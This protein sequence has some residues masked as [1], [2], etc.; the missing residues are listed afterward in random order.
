[1]YV[2]S[3]IDDASQYETD[4]QDALKPLISIALEI[5]KLPEFVKRDEPTVIT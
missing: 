2:D 3:F 5:S 1:M 4:A